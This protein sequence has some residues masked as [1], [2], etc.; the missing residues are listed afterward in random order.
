MTMKPHTPNAFTVS[1]L[2]AVPKLYAA[3]NRYGFDNLTLTNESLLYTT[4][5][6]GGYDYTYTARFLVKM[7][8]NIEVNF[9]FS[10]DE[11]GTFEISFIGMRVQEK[12][13]RQLADLIKAGKQTDIMDIDNL[14]MGS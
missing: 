13:F 2:K 14:V 8:R 5:D 6:D 1:Y 7:K 3:L 4:Q 10:I 11:A 9:S 12:H